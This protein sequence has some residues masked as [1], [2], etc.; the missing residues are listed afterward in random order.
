MHGDVGL[1]RV[2]QLEPLVLD[3]E[4][5]VELLTCVDR[6]DPRALCRVEDVRHSSFL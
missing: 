6:A 4:R 1:R 5:L 3:P 2:E